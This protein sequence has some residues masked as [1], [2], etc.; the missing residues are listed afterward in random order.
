MISADER[1]GKLVQRPEDL[2]D[3][4]SRDYLRR[5]SIELQR[6]LLTQSA[7]TKDFFETFVDAAKLAELR[8]SLRQRISE[9]ATANG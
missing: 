8:N 1:W 5:L 6:R 3:V 4:K 2:D 9:I 7:W